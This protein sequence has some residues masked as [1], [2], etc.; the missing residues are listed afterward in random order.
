MIEKII[1]ETIVPDLVALGWTDQIGWLV[2]PWTKRIEV[3]EG[4]FKDLIYPVATN[5]INADCEVQ[6]YGLNVLTT[7]KGYSSLILI[8]T[9]GD[10]V[11]TTAENIPQRRALNIE[12]DFIIK[13]WF[14]GD[15]GRTHIAEMDII[16]AFFKKVYRQQSITWGLNGGTDSA[17]NIY[18]NKLKVNFLREISG[19]PFEEYDFGKDQA[20]LHGNYRAIGLVFKMT[21]LIFPNCVPAYPELGEEC[22]NATNVFTVAAVA[23]DST[24][25]IGDDIVI[26]G[27]VVG[28]VGT[29]SY[30]W[31]IKVGDEWQDIEDSTDIILTYNTEGSESPTDIFRLKI[32]KLGISYYSASVT[33]TILALPNGIIDAELNTITNRNNTRITYQGTAPEIN[34][35]TFQWQ[36]LD[37]I[38]WTNLA[39]H[40]PAYWI[41]VIGGDYPVGF[42]SFRCITTNSNGCSIT[43]NVEIIEI[44]A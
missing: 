40:D 8:E 43:S 18:V 6:E 33:I 15:F 23:E 42:N 36:W 37:D 26:N 22:D 2:K 29:P 4:Q 32:T 20:Q 14:N 28:G 35:L 17:Y 10:M 3:G 5:V 13:V 11:A 34:D 12:Q 19:N 25:C 41:L 21:G 9:E 7:D 44:T 24:V 31:Q 30:Q 39:P 1:G 27:S 16:K 38:T